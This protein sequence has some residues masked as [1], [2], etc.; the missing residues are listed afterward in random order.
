M[1]LES[2]SESSL[3]D[4]PL[5]VDNEPILKNFCGTVKNDLI[6]KEIP[7]SWRISPE[8]F[9]LSAGELGTLQKLGDHLLKF[10]R[11]QN[12]LY[13]E[14]VRGTQPQWI[15][16]YL[17]L[18][19]P[20]QMIDFGRMNRFKSSLPGIIRPDIIL[21]P[22]GMTIS[23][24]DSIPGG[25]GLTHQLNASY[26]KLGYTII[27]KSDGM[28]AGFRKMV[29]DLAG[30]SKT[31]RTVSGSEKE[32]N[33]ARTE[34]A[35]VISEESSDYR[36]EMASFIK[37]LNGPDLGARL[38]R[39]E[40][41]YFTEEAVYLKNGEEKTPV[42]LLYRFLEL[43]DYKN[44][45]K[46][47]LLLYASKKEK[48]I[49][50]P[51]FKAFLEE[52]LW[53]ALFHHP[54]LKPYWKIELGDETLNFLKPFIPKTWILDP[55]ELPPYGVIPDLML[56]EKQVSRWEELFDAGQKERRFVI[57]PSGFSELA[58]GARG[59][60]VG[61]D[62]SGRDW[63][64][65]LR[66]ALASFYQT[67]HVLQEYH[68]G[69]KEDFVY[70]N[71]ETRSLAKMSGRT[72]LCPYYFVSGSE[73]MLGGILATTC[74]A[75]KKIVHGMSDAIMAPCSLISPPREKS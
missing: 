19:K 57:K 17:D 56:R 14:S 52:K 74:P 69:R 41:V 10:Y 47:D 60:K 25:F 61:H 50:T 29:F 32:K 63:Q 13:F 37:E 5:P 1:A 59:V 16:F 65:S 15:S 11:A 30:N 22:E 9:Y 71:E 72:R 12:K 67:P 35:M 4:T 73:T 26:A 51:P 18:G 44:I 42:N 21:T 68:Q 27:G 8:P 70:F 48:I 49:T 62:L 31:G 33:S 34:L 3:E 23:E 58:W 43:F 55:R 46:I 24:L 40:E 6:E 38:C 36:A 2:I 7:P 53:F 45:P 28:A 20:Q 75:D 66:N 64:E 39:P 54:A